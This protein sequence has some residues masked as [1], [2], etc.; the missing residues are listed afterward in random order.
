MVKMRILPV[1]NKLNLGFTLLELI[2]VLALMGLIM[3]VAM[4]ALFSAIPGLQTR[5]AVKELN[6]VLR[7][8]KATA[9]TSGED[10]VV[11]LDLEHHIFYIAGD[12][13]EYSLPEN[14]EI[15]IDSVE[16]ETLSD[17]VSGF[18][19]FSDGSSTGGRITLKRDGWHYEINIDWL[20][21]RIEIIDLIEENENY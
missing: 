18:R 19:F 21:G 9:L 20:S 11:L 1:G 10:Q 8:A 15:D 6:S 7:Y 4:P 16:S 13:K 2:V 12:D 5:G 14:L 17:Q 3:A